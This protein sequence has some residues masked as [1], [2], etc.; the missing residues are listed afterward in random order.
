[1]LTTTST[2]AI[3]IAATVF[4]TFYA[5]NNIMII[6]DEVNHDFNMSVKL[7]SPHSEFSNEEKPTAKSE[8]L[9]T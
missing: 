3:C 2:I 1:M 7:L 9:F 8:K 5:R 4:C 6:N